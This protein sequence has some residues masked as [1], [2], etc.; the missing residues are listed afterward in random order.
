MQNPNAL[1]TN[2]LSII[3]NFYFHNNKIDDYKHLMTPTTTNNQAFSSAEQFN[4][5]LNVQNN[6]QE[7]ATQPQNIPNNPNLIS[8]FF[9]YRP[10]NI[11]T[12]FQQSHQVGFNNNI[13]IFVIASN[14]VNVLKFGHFLENNS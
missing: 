10:K 5:S 4:Q 12:Q 14:I 7:A 8:P 2:H 9:L 13:M 3:N 6:P 1:N 11:S